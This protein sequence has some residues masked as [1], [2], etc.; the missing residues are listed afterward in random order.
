MIGLLTII[1][2]LLVLIIAILFRIENKIDALPQV[3]EK[4]KK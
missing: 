1:G 4:E 2:F 3:T